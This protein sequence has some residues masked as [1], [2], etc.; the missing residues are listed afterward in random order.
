MLD[1]VSTGGGGGGSGAVIGYVAKTA[2]FTVQVSYRGKIIDVDTTL[3][4]VTVTQIAA[5]T[6]GSGFSYII[7]KS[8]SDANTVI[9]G[10][11]DGGAKT[12]TKVNE[13][14]L[15]VST[16][17]AYISQTWQD[18]AAIAITAGTINGT[19]IGATSATTGRFTTV[20]STIAT[21]TAPLI[22][23]STTVVGNLNV[24]QLLGSTWAAPGTIG[25]G[26]PSTGAFTTISATGQIT[27][28]LASGTAP[29]VIASTTVVA[30]LNAS[31]LLGSTWAAPGTI[32]SG[33]PSTGAFTTLS[34]TGVITSTLATGTAPFTVASTTVV[35]NLNVSRLLGGTW[36]A[37]GTIGSGTPSTGAFTTISATGQITSTLATGSAPFVVAST[38]NV[39]NLNAS[40]L[41]GATFAAPGAIGG[42]TPGSGAFTTL[43]ATGVI[44]STLAT[45]TAP[46]TV[47]STTVVGNLNVSALLGSTW[48]A[49]AALGSGTPAAV[50][51][52]TITATVGFTCPLLGT[53]NESF[54]SGAGVGLIAG[55]TQNCFFGNGAGNAVTTGDDN[56]AVGKG[57][58]LL[59]TTNSGNIAIGTSALAAVTTSANL[60]VAVGH[61][62]LTALTSGIQCTAVGYQAGTTNLIGYGLTAFGY[63]VL[64]VATGDDNVA[65]GALAGV[66][67]STGISNTLI[68]SGCAAELQT[69]SKNVCVGTIAMNAMR[70]SDNIA[71]GYET[72]NG[73]GTPANNTGSRN[74]A[75]GTDALKVVSSGSDNLALGHNALF[76]MVTGSANIALGRSA[77][78][79]ATGSNTLY[80]G[81]TSQGSY[82]INTITIASAAAAG[83]SFS[84]KLSFGAAVYYTPVTLSDSATIAVD[85]SLG[86]NFVIT[87]T[88]S[89]HTLGNPTNAV[90]G[91]VINVEIVQGGTGSYTMLYDTQYTFT[92][93]YPTGTLSTAVGKRDVRSFKYVASNVWR[94]I[95]PLAKDN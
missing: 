6:A 74:L 84:T 2:D 88:A 5:A 31:L 36:A 42:G 33:T 87:L 34:A 47:A 7:R 39:A 52:T 86:N 92:T 28:T 61:Q 43:S 21:G 22:V 4:N 14:R 18:P 62:A 44:T 63:Q 29:L 16:G 11:V 66:K 32:G 83:A 10:T 26:T 54:G 59:A 85:A 8:T 50:T 71:L 56:V 17:A 67:V 55:G 76:S 3:G 41:S 38:T 81:D 53:N 72:M 9:L 57:A 12:L 94:A 79:A 49:P 70:G 58:L 95:S 45:G 64:K 89:G 75:A 40:S 13:G 23:A 19:T 25:N 82:G 68:G 46:F 65:M 93:D 30:N 78:Y 91:Q 60:S 69:T 15:I 51:G 37:P 48:A 1:P 20:E 80:I 24:S 77:G 35:G 73:S 27:S 90:I